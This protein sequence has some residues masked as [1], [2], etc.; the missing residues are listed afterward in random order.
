MAGRHVP[1]ALKDVVSFLKESSSQGLLNTSTVESNIKSRLRTIASDV[2]AGRTSLPARDDM[3]LLQAMSYLPD[4]YQEWSNSVISRLTRNASQMSLSRDILPA[5]MEWV[6]PLNLF[7]L[8]LQKCAVK[9]NNSSSSSNGA[10]A[11][12]VLMEHLRGN[13]WGQHHLSSV[14]RCLLP[15]MIPSHIPP[16]ILCRMLLSVMK[17]DDVEGRNHIL[18]NRGWC[19]RTMCCVPAWPLQS[20]VEVLA[21]HSP[22]HLTTVTCASTQSTFLTPMRQ[23]IFTQGHQLHQHH[24][25]LLCNSFSLCSQSDLMFHDQ[26]SRSNVY[27]SFGNILWETGFRWQSKLTPKHRIQLLKSVTICNSVVDVHQTDTFLPDDVLHHAFYGN[28]TEG[29]LDDVL[30]T[31]AMHSVSRQHQL[32]RGSSE[33]TKWRTIFDRIRKVSKR[34]SSELEEFTLNAT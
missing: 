5:A 3:L 9:D 17:C 22:T 19:D 12:A 32:L 21:S 20:L 10:E 33:C 28:G 8:L 4:V 6:I 7:H 1:T 14:V 26:P 24:V 34:D 16:P 15:R 25:S 29:A 18:N 23:I 27:E 13:S 11:A 2:S 30:T 31:H